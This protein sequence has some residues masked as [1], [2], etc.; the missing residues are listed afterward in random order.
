M[1]ARLIFVLAGL[2]LLQAGIEANNDTRV[3]KCELSAHDGADAPTM[4]CCMLDLNDED[5]RREYEAYLTDHCVKVDHQLDL[6]S[7][8]DKLRDF[9][10]KASCRT[11]RGV[12]AGVCTATYLF[13]AQTIA[14]GATTLIGCMNPVTLIV[15]AAIVSNAVVG[16]S[17]VGI[18]ASLC[19]RPSAAT[20]K[21][22]LHRFLAQVADRESAVKQIDDT[23]AGGQIVNWS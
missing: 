9:L 22:A 6:M 19:T 13:G 4:Q 15:S 14:A 21:E 23:V 10:K 16:G 2:A 20:V 18:G 1:S 5:A 12:T 3:I 17:L 8:N 11:T 7:P